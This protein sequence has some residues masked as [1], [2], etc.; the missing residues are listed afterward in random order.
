LKL[1]TLQLKSF[2][3]KDPRVL[4]TDSQNVRRILLVL[5]EEFNITQN[6]IKIYNSKN[7]HKLDH[8][9][10]NIKLAKNFNKFLYLN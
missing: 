2:V 9:S 1:S 6:E 7:N 5:Q 8:V 10:Q 3:L 4:R